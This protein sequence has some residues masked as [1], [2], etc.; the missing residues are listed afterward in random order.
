MLLPVLVAAFLL[1]AEVASM[2]CADLAGTQTQPVRGR[3]GMAA[4]LKV[5]SADDHRKNSHD[6]EAQYQLVITPTTGPAVVVAL[7][8]SDAGWDRSL[9]LRLSGFSQNGQRVFGVLSEDG[10]FPSTALFDYNTADGTVRLINLTERFAHI[11]AA[12]CVATSNIIGSTT[13]GA[14]VLELRSTEPRA[15]SGR[16]LL[17]PAGT[18]VQRLPQ[19]VSFLNLYEFKDDAP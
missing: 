10:K 13:T 15:P 3:D 16:W 11:V 6:C 7:L 18:T 1:P 2:P 8:T 14:I 4:L 17:N 19:H 12:K 9:S 5:S